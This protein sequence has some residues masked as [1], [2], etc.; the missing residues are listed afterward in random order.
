VDEEGKTHSLEEILRK[1]KVPYIPAAEF[2]MKK[3]AQLSQ[4]TPS[5]KP[6]DT[7]KIVQTPSGFNPIGLATQ[8]T[9]LEIEP[10]NL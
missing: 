1:N 7:G 4:L 10:S 6:E 9:S 3:K 2:E 5:G 8:G